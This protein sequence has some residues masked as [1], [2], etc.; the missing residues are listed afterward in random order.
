MCPGTDLRLLCHV[1]WSG[2]EEI[3]VGFLS[4]IL[5]TESGALCAP[6]Q[7]LHFCVSFIALFL[8]LKMFHLEIGSH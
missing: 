1:L 6:G 8:R 2:S 3:S 4:P 5:S 7:A